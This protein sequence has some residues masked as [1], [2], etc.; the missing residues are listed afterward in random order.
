[1]K[2]AYELLQAEGYIETRHG[3]GSFVSAAVPDQISKRQ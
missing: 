1:M 3:A 2:A